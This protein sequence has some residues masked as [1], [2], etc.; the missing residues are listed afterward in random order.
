VR[1]VA[2]A[3]GI[4]LVP[5]LWASPA[6][7][8]PLGNFT[9]SRYAG[10]HLAPGQA[11]VDYVVDMAEIPTFQAIETIDDDGDGVLAE[12]ELAAWAERE[13]SALSRELQLLLAGNRVP[14]STESALASLAPGQGGLNTLRLDITF[15]GPTGGD[16]GVV[17]FRD[18]SDDGRIG[19][20]EVTLDA[21]DGVAITDTSVP[22]VSVSDEL[23]AYPN[24]LLASPLDVTSARATLAPGTS[25]ALQSSAAAATTGRPGVESSPLASVLAN[26]GAPLVLIGLFVAF[27]VGAWHALLPGHGKTLMAAAMVGSGANAP[28]AI[29]IAAA[30]ALMHTASVLTLGIG[31]LALE[32]T[33]R[34]EALYPWLAV[35]SGTAA[36][37]VG[38]YLLKARWSALRHHR[39]APASAQNTAQHRAEHTVDDTDGDHGHDHAVAGE[40]HR[41][42]R[43]RVTALAFS[44]GILPA[45]SALLVMLG[46]IQ[47]HRV[48]Y[49]LSLVV[50]FSIGLA[51][52]LLAIG[53]GALRARD[54]VE[55][56]LSQRA[57]FL[58]P[59]VSAA[60]VLLVGVFVT[61]RAATQV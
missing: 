26:H 35:A 50:A 15:A 7:A 19:W 32:R 34:P 55:R 4:V 36:V 23:R 30:V 16:A 20:R 54:A 3:F 21:E 53:L 42:N 28:Q 47:A 11:R 12:A 27:A 38:A 44:G 33:F 41:L 18:R 46:A 31:V 43:R 14:L 39:R 58:V 48:A 10:V 17:E 6:A 37:A 25:R 51:V 59:V 56:R 5:L 57:A 9:V 49:G 45:P 24:D 8:H 60:A 52:A 2:A 1:R 13:A 29:G 22:S 40:G 61:V